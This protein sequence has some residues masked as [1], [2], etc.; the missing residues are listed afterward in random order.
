MNNIQSL[1]QRDGSYIITLLKSINTYLSY[2]ELH[3]M[4]GHLVGNDDITGVLAFGEGLNGSGTS[5]I[6]QVV[7]DAVDEH[8]IRD[9]HFHIV[10]EGLPFFY[11]LVG[12]GATVGYV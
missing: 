5:D 8:R 4:V 11:S 6:V 1:R 3:T 2:I 10:G 7:I 12:S 9:R